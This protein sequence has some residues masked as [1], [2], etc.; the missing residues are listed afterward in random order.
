MT[1]QKNARD[2]TD[3]NPEV[4]G[5]HPVPLNT[6]H[7]RS[8]SASSPKSL[9][10]SIMMNKNR[11]SASP[12][13]PVIQHSPPNNNQLF[14]TDSSSPSS[15]S[16]FHQNNP[17]R[18]SP[19][20]G[21]SLSDGL[22]SMESTMVSQP[23][24][25]HLVKRSGTKMFTGQ[26][27]TT[28]FASSRKRTFL[29]ASPMISPLLLPQS[30]NEAGSRDSGNLTNNLN[31]LSEQPSE[32]SVMSYFSAWED[33]NSQ[34]SSPQVDKEVFSSGVY[35]V[36]NRSSSPSVAATTSPIPSYLQDDTSNNR[37]TNVSKSR[38]FTTFISKIFGRND[39]M[40]SEGIKKAPK[41]NVLSSL[42]ED[43]S[44]WLAMSA[45]T[46]FHTTDSVTT[47]DPSDS[48]LNNTSV[49][50]AVGE[51]D[52]ETRQKNSFTQWFHA[53]S[54]KCPELFEKEGCVYFYKKSIKPQ[55]PQKKRSST[56]FSAALPLDE[57]IE[58]LP[59]SNDVFV[60]RF[61]SC[62]NQVVTIFEK[63]SKD[64]PG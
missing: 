52:L 4:E 9:P 31:S 47:V 16:N 11:P 24:S 29:K 6:T 12:A 51:N 15:P 27:P 26:P 13:S 37:S 57:S 62:K 43:D 14:R 54:M 8:Q 17:R 49:S 18:R 30:L 60:E 38:K 34:V 61:I 32:Q 22:N 25:D 50:D 20:N 46:D 42:I 3:E 63:G 58:P 33:Y 53:K 1:Q 23:N 28:S 44:S 35:E 10:V 45:P 41:R 56:Q 55:A 48:K 21:T 5:N 40:N 64:S 2:M 39:G 36:T 59:Q 19:S 7:N